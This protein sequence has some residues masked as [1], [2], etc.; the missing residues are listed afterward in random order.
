[1]LWVSR[2]KYYHFFESL[3]REQSKEVIHLPECK[4]YLAFS[5]ATHTGRVMIR[6]SCFFCQGNIWKG[7]VFPLGAHKHKGQN[8][9]DKRNGYRI[10]MQT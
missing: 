5:S 4:G 2:G 8:K 1:M 9:Q 10:G 6:A 7:T 3:C